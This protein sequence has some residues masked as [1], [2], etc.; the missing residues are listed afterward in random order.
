MNNLGTGS[1]NSMHL[2]LSPTTRIDLKAEEIID[3]RSKQTIRKRS[4][5]HN[6]GGFGLISS[7]VR[8]DPSTINELMISFK[9][10]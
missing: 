3:Q 6:L 9:I 10:G 7:A 1:R 4:N 2:T 8:S 5:S